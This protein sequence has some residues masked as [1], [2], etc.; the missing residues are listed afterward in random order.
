MQVYAGET[1]GIVGVNGSGKSTLLQMI[2]GTLKETKGNIHV[3]GKVAAILELGSGFNM[4]FTGIENIYLN[5]ILMGM[6]KR[7]ID[8][9]INNIIEFADIGP[10][11]NQPLRT[12]SSG[13]VVRL[14]FAIMTEVKADIL[15]I[16]EAL[17]VGDAIFTQKCMRYIKK[18][19]KKGTILFVSHDTSAVLSL[20][21][22]A[23]LLEEGIKKA[24]G[25]TKK[26]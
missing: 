7:E 10:Y 20:C 24:D 11:I 14:A 23:I 1:V 15:V 26:L 16:D 5:G 6:E 18:F 3:D 22:R 2:C 9:K 21:D 17:A 8:D 13:M 12:Y 25:K 19:K 4:E